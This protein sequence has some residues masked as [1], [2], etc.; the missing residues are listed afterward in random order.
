VSNPLNVFNNQWVIY[1]KKVFPAALTGCRRP[2]RQSP[3]RSFAVRKGAVADGQQPAG[4][5]RNGIKNRLMYLTGFCA[6]LL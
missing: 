4:A 5:T 2:I 1:D 6:A 3:G